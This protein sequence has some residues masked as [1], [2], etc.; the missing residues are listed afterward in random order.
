MFLISNANMLIEAI[1][2]GITGCVPAHNYRTDSQFRDA[3][4]MIREKATGPIGVN[5]I[6]NKSNIK[7]KQQ[8]KSCLE[9]KIDYIITSLGSPEKTI[10]A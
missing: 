9:L 5:L 10:N 1:N 7:F 8:L 2:S 6:V 4:K 3:I